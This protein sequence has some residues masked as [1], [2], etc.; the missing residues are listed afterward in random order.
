[1]TQAWDPD[2]YARFCDE[3]RQPLLDLLAMVQPVPGGRAVD[4]GCGTG[5]LTWELHETKQLAET[6]GID[7]SEAML[8]RAR[9][10]AEVG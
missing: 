6:V 1:M 8:T 2:Q 3:R 4:L 10:I 9:P 7:N 5:D